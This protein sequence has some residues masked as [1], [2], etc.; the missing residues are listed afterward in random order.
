MIDYLKAHLRKEIYNVQIAQL[1]KCGHIIRSECVNECICMACRWLT[2]NVEGCVPLEDDEKT[3]ERIADAILTTCGEEL[4]TVTQGHTGTFWRVTF[5]R[6]KW[7][8]YRWFGAPGNSDVTRMRLDCGAEAFGL[9]HVPL[10]NKTPD[11]LRYVDSIVPEF[12]PLIDEVAVDA[13]KTV[14]EW[15]IRRIAAKAKK[16]P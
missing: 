2:L 10:T 13:R 15:K 7:I 9:P 5:P 1:E 8:I 14:M 12:D 11:I 3:P 6:T 4:V 16:G